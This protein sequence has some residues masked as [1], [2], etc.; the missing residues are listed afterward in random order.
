MQLPSTVLERLV[1]LP[2]VDRRLRQDA[3]GLRIGKVRSRGKLR[4]VVAHPNI[5]VG[6]TAR[7]VRRMSELA[8]FGL[9][10]T[11]GAAVSVE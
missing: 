5:E 2:C 6:R 10:R 11:P 8:A 7:Q 3:N 9:M 1:E 4:L